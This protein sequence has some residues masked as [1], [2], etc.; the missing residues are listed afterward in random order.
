MGYLRALL[1]SESSEQILIFLLARENGYPTEI[2]KFFNFSLDAIQKQME[3]LEVGNVLAS[4]A[5]GRTRVYSFNPRYPFL[6][7]LKALLQKALSFYPKDL[8]EQLLMNRRRPR[9]AGKP[10]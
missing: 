2:S 8:Q 9:R 5:I 3:K 1:G 6:K 7:E 4:K 10:L